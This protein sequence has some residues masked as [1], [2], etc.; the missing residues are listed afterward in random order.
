MHML[1]STLRLCHDRPPLQESGSYFVVLSWEGGDN[2]FS[3][4]SGVVRAI[5]ALWLQLQY[6]DSLWWLCCCHGG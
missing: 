2:L 5:V 1:G 6:S 4:I 3:E